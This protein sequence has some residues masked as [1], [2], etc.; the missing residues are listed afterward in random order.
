[1]HKDF[2]Q[3][4]NITSD[5][6]LLI[7]L[8]D[9]FT[10]GQGALSDE[11]WSLYNYSSEERTQDLRYDELEEELSNSWVHQMC[12]NHMPSY[13]P[14]NLGFRGNG[15]K[16]SIKNLTTLNSD[17]NI[18]SAKEK[19]VIFHL[20]DMMRYDYLNDPLSNTNEHNHYTTM[21][22][23]TAA[24]K[25]PEWKKALWTGYRG[26]WSEGFG[27]VEFLINIQDLKNWCKLHDAKL[28]L[29]SAFSQ[30]Y[31]KK[32]FEHHLIHYHYNRF[33]DIIDWEN[34]FYYPEGYNCFSDLL[35]VKEGREDWIGT[36]DW[37]WYA[38]KNG[39]TKDGWFTPC[40]HPSVKGHALIAE[41]IFQEIYNRGWVKNATIPLI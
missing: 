12:K 24:E 36:Q 23:H 26:F 3:K 17:L 19:I 29:T 20:T 22:P 21:W 6:R 32:Y 34:D 31:T 28:I 33:I 15:N 9:S 4:Y 14:V 7:G 40:A 2:K 18:E 27:C 37:Y 41:K 38:F 10:E 5:S 1:M 25:D 13:T 30:E 8:G 39:G 16:S 35:C 11:T